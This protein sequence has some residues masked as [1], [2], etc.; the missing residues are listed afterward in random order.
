[1]RKVDPMT[2]LNAIFFE[3]KRVYVEHNVNCLNY[4]REFTLGKNIA[5]MSEIP[6]T[7]LIHGNWFIID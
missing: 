4:S 1:M 6:V 5:M 2:A 3:N 7:V